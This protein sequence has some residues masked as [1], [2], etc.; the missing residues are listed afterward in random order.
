M[1]QPDG[2]SAWA[3]LG[4]ETLPLLLWMA[5]IAQG[6]LTEPTGLGRLE[7]L[8]LPH[9]DK[10]A[11]ALLY[12]ILGTLL[13]RAWTGQRE[14]VGG[15][16]SLASALALIAAA[17]L[18]GGY[19]EVLQGL[20]PWRTPDPMDAVANLTG[21]AVG[22]AAWFGWTRAGGGMGFNGGKQSGDKDGKSA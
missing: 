13:A 20:T 3:R 4:R 1:G 16:A 7:W 21:A 6:S 2:P 10:L 15:R 8:G 22:T 11:H 12:L 9:G 17:G 19:L 5:L 18:W 14:M